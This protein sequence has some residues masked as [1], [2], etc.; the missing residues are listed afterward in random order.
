MTRSERLDM[1][2]NM[3]ARLSPE[4]GEHAN[5]VAVYAVAV[6][7]E[8]GLTDRRLQRL[9]DLALLFVAGTRRPGLEAAPKRAEKIWRGRIDSQILFMCDEYVIFRANSTEEALGKLKELGYDEALL[10]ALAKVSQ[11]IQP[12][13]T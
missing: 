4:I 12:V 13:G 9:H 7:S 6:G 10:E 11:I 3:L 5:R 1:L 2:R 8:I